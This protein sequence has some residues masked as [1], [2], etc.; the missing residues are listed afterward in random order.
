MISRASESSQ[1]AVQ[2]EDQSKGRPGDQV[3]GSYSGPD[4]RWPE[5]QVRSWET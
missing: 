1:M 2:R 4:D 3:G 5:E